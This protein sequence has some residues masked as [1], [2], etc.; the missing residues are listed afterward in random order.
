M[1]NRCVDDIYLWLCSLRSQAPY[2]MFQQEW[3]NHSLF[4]FVEFRIPKLRQ[5]CT[6]GHTVGTS[7]KYFCLTI[8]VTLT[9]FTKWNMNVAYGRW[10]S[11]QSLVA[12]IPMNTCVMAVSPENITKI[13]KFIFSKERCSVGP[14]GLRCERIKN[15][16]TG[17]KPFS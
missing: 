11:Y 2:T 17:R 10:C 13:Y 4:N 15:D 9:V 7:L 6:W 14:V 3:C 16:E 1:G 8:P 5:S 12:R